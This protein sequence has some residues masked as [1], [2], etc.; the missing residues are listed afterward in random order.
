MFDDQIDVLLLILFNFTI[1]IPTLINNPIK[2]K[3]QKIVFKKDNLSN[4]LLIK[5][6]I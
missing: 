6:I 4:K 3:I 5:Y 2:T 1:V